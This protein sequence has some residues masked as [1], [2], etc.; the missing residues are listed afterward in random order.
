ML[1]KLIC[2]RH[3]ALTAALV[4]RTTPC[5]PEQLQARHLHVDGH[6]MRPALVRV[7]VAL[8]AAL[9]ALWL[10]APTAL[11]V[12]GNLNDGS[13]V[14]DGNPGEWDPDINGADFYAF[15]Y[16]AGRTDKPIISYLYLR[17]DCSDQTMYAYVS[18]PDFKLNTSNDAEHWIKLGLGGGNVVDASDDN[19]AF[20]G[21]DPVTNRAEGWEASFSLAPGVYALDVHTLYVD[22]NDDET[23]ATPPLTL[24]VDCACEGAT[25]TATVCEDVNENGICDDGEGR[26]TNPKLDIPVL[27]VPSEPTAA[28]PI[29]IG[30]TDG[31]GQ[32]TFVAPRDGFIVP[33]LY[34]LQVEDAYLITQGYYNTTPNAAS[35]YVARCATIEREFGYA[36]DPDGAVGDL[37][38]Y[39][40]DGDG[41]QDEWYDGDPNG[42]TGA[43]DQY[44]VTGTPIP[45]R[46]FEW[47]DVN[48]D[49][50][51][52]D[53]DDEGELNKCGIA[54]VA[55]TLAGSPPQ[56]TQT[57]QL[58]YYRFSNL[59]LGAT[60]TT[61]IDPNDAALNAGAEAYFID[62]KCA[63]DI[64]AS[65]AAAARSP[66]FLRA[67]AVQTITCSLT[68]AG[69][70]PLNSNTS[71]ELTEENDTDLTLDYSIVCSGTPLAVTLSEFAAERA[72]DV[73][74]F[75]WQTVS[76]FGNAGFNLYAE[77]DAGMAQINDALIPSK[78]I[79]SV[80][81]VDYSYS[82]TVAGERFYL[83]MVSIDGVN[84]IFGPTAAQETSQSTVWIP[85]VAR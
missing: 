51:Y 59:P 22:E 77:T 75:R 6:T 85:F 70:P 69:D 12:E 54:G 17:Y 50:N 23:S 5:L 29:L 60:Y 9:I 48:R 14:V 4:K 58:G 36:E 61:S 39:D 71:F 35:F 40:A 19:F 83:E 42:T 78:V 49:G 53:P 43:V 79:D 64:P 67:G 15:M 3:Y 57:S 37:V 41:R 13:A 81:H 38:W 44:N 10:V 7:G 82:A 73:V 32:V 20:V 65:P 1:T 47:I 56:T 66:Q 45:L 62:G 55:V 30:S 18:S 72:G 11:A 74:N 27:L 21:F 2:N 52:G 46:E 31:A 80:V 24:T 33:G 68:G 63:S 28:N 8:I 76:E 34:T 25:I 84:T 26:F 16:Q